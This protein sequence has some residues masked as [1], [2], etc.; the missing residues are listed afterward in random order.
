MK[1][2]IPPPVQ[3]I[4]C[5]GLMWLIAEQ[6]P[7]F[8][9]SSVIQQPLAILICIIGIGIDLVSVGLFAR[10]KT[11]VSPFSPNKTEV[12]VTSGLY[13]YTRNPMYLGMACIL[14]GLGVWLGNFASF[15]MI[16]CFVWYITQLQIIPEEEILLEKFGEEYGEYMLRVRRW[17]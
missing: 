4:I 1:L 13:Q 12:L 17:I 6:F 11:T 3:A 10:K 15:A 7:E 2:I 9:F 16:P 8:S 5:A 14:T